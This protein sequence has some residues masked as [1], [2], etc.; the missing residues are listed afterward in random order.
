I[1]AAI[2][3]IIDNFSMIIF[4]ALFSFIF[5]IRQE[6]R[7]I[8]IVAS[9]I[10][11]GGVI[12]VIIMS[13]LP[14][15]I[16][17]KMMIAV[18]G[19]IFSINI[20]VML[21]LKKSVQEAEK[22]PENIFLMKEEDVD[23]KYFI[24][25]LTKNK[26]LILLVLI[27]FFSISIEWLIDFKFHD[28]T[29][30]KFLT[31]EEFSS[32]LGIFKGSMSLFFTLF[33]I[34]ILSVL[35]RK[36][37]FTKIIMIHPILMFFSG[38]FLAVIGGF[39][40]GLFARFGNEFVLHTFERSLNHIFY[41]PLNEKVREKL[42]AFLEGMIKPVFICFA[43]IVILLLIK[44]SSDYYIII[45]I[46][47][48]L[49][50]F[51]WLI[52]N[53]AMKKEYKKVL[54]ES[55]VLD[56]NENKEKIF[57]QM[58]EHASGESRE[59]ILGLLNSNSD[60]FIQFA[61]EMIEKHD[62]RQ[63]NEIVFEIF[64]KG[65]PALQ[66]LAIRILLREIDNN[67]LLN[68]VNELFIKGNSE[69]RQAILM[70]FADISFSKIEGFL[71]DWVRMEPD[72]ESFILSLDLLVHGAKNKYND[73]IADILKDLL[74]DSQEKQT[75]ALQVIKS[76]GIFGL[77]E[78]IKRFINER[79]EKISS[80]VLSII[81]RYEIEIG[82]S[83]VVSS[84]TSLCSIDLII[85][86][87]ANMNRKLIY[88]IFSNINNYEND[89]RRKLWISLPFIRDVKTMDMFA[90][91]EEFTDDL[92]LAEK[93]S[94]MVKIKEKLDSNLWELYFKDNI[95]RS[96]IRWYKLIFNKIIEELF[97]LKMLTQSEEQSL[98]SLFSLYHL[99]KLESYEKNLLDL[100]FLILPG[101]GM[102]KV[103]LQILSD[104]IEL[105]AVALELFENIL[106]SQDI[107]QNTNIIV[108]LFEYIELHEKL[109]YFKEY[110]L[111][112][113][114]P[115]NILKSDIETG[116]LFD[117]VINT[118]ILKEI[119]IE[120]FK[121][122]ETIFNKEGVKEMITVINRL[123][124]LKDIPLF[125]SMNLDSLLK[126]SMISNFKI[127]NQ[128]DLIIC[129]N[130]EGKALY[131]ITKGKA[132]VGRQ[133]KDEWVRIAELNQGEFFGEMSI[134]TNEL[135]SADIRAIEDCEILMINKKKFR[136]L[137]YNNP[138]LSFEIFNVLSRRLKKVTSAEF[139]R[140]SKTERL[141]I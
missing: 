122:Y 52:T 32:F 71:C 21:L 23:L 95:N 94:V 35:I 15:I 8:S 14:E 34:F 45:S 60:P 83:K 51:A 1:M 103:R 6:K 36:I 28:I 57:E 70:C 29:S 50:S 39:Y 37:G 80:L 140:F 136:D 85:S 77:Q 42:R 111:N 82:Y 75:T 22:D 100:I 138:E 125:K 46:I 74:Y 127:Y 108:D 96:Y 3:E 20:I 101:E 105:K 116:S 12:A 63:F 107:I 43:S 47:I 118:L 86:E 91:K 133:I 104:N 128:G 119:S 44:L 25:K 24:N 99:E 7:L 135:T 113:D 41:S 66:H 98:I 79:D 139:E 30:H 69:Q 38:G 27:I 61:L 19:G 56:S 33:N 59:I 54:I 17:V 58:F 87:I 13:F 97:I 48:M 68:R 40:S 89:V 67:Y 4:A 16:G 123:V 62:I 92:E 102:E 10:G 131:I 141:Y 120:K 137:I 84:L 55:L 2:V 132:L 126:I 129:E 88:K 73:F 121:K 90:E 72:P 64:E 49:F 53:I 5:N 18:S 112:F 130:E 110:F 114:D 115:V 124:F 65:N 81:I 11:V 26:Y 134:F 76:V 9:G 93:I 117:A 78:E 106:N 31:E 109:E